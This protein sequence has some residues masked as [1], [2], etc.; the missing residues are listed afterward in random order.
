[1]RF[2]LW[3]LMI[4]LAVLIVS[5][6][7]SIPDPVQPPDLT[8]ETTSKNE[9]ENHANH[10]LLSLQKAVVSDDHQSV[11]IIP[12][13]GAEMH[14]NA[15]KMLEGGMCDDCLT[16][17]NVQIPAPGE[18]W[19]DLTIRHPIENNL[20]FTVFDP[21]A[22]FITGADFTFPESQRS[23]SLDSTYPRL[24]NPDGYT[25]LFNPTEFPE[26]SPV[27]PA[28]KYF[29]GKFSTGGDL[30]ASL[31]PFIA[32]ATEFPRRMFL[33]GTEETETV[34]L[35]VP[36]G[37][38]QFGYAID[39]CWSDPGIPVTDPETDFPPKANCT[40][41]YKITYEIIGTVKPEMGSS[42]LLYVE[43]SD[44]QGLDTIGDARLEVPDLFNGEFPLNFSHA[45]DE[46]TFLFKGTIA[47]L[48]GAEAGSYPFLITI[49]SIQPD[50]N[51]GLVSAYQV[52][53]IEIP[54]FY[55]P[56][57]LADFDPS[58][59]YVNQP[60]HFFDDGSH[61]PDGGNIVK[62]EWD[63]NLDGV[64]DE[65][66]ADVW[67][68]WDTA[69]IYS[70]QFRVTDDE[71]AIGELDEPL[72]VEII[73][74]TIPVVEVTPEWLNCEQWISHV[75][76]NCLV[77]TDSS[78][79]LHFYD[80]TDPE[81]P[82]W[83]CQIDAEYTFYPHHFASQ[84]GYLY[85]ALSNDEPAML[86]IDVDPPQETH[87]VKSVPLDIGSPMYVK[88]IA[89]HD[90]LAW[91]CPPSDVIIFVD[92]TIPEDATQIGWVEAP[93]SFSCNKTVFEGEYTYISADSGLPNITVFKVDPPDKIEY[94][95]TV[96]C[97]SYDIEVYNGYT[98][99]N[100]HVETRILDIDP[101]DSCEIINILP[102]IHGWD[103][104]VANGYLYGYSVGGWTIFDIDP[105]G[106]AYIVREIDSPFV[107]RNCALTDGYAY[108][109]NEYV[110]TSIIDIDPPEE[111][112]I[113]NMIQNVNNVQDI[114]KDGDILY[115]T[116]QNYSYDL[117]PGW[118]Q[119]LDVT[120]PAITNVLYSIHLPTYAEELDLKDGYAFGA[121]KDVL[122]VIDIDPPESAHLVTEFPMNGTPQ[123]M[124]IDGSH[125]YITNEFGLNIIDISVPESPGSV[126][127]IPVPGTPVMV[128]TAYGYAY[129]VFRQPD[130]SCKMAVVDIDPPEDAFI[131]CK[132][133]IKGDDDPW[134]S[135]G[136]IDIAGSF[137]YIGTEDFL[138]IVD[139]E[140][141][142][143]P[144]IICDIES[145]DE[146]CTSIQ[147]VGNL[148][149]VSW[150]GMLKIIDISTPEHAFIL[151]E[152][153]LIKGGN[154]L[155]D[156]NYIYTSYYGLRIFEFI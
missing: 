122:N 137:V 12:L 55:N 149:Y 111:A 144:E 76:G 57:A 60:V 69:G 112:H 90:N 82:V 3:I 52:C 153:E 43:I 126:K 73:K 47:N 86:V 67:H 95:Q 116:S 139:I 84:D 138:N 14:L 93:I 59:A 72:E 133:D 136:C 41:A 103:F 1:M 39:V 68:S 106:D 85:V 75:E 121:G 150:G 81:N 146:Y 119:L 115:I 92:I 151:D 11:E 79:R 53:N 152:I 29:P 77:L 7:N 64:Y 91:I 65:E 129:V 108:V 44:H 40:E 101:P 145:V 25:S 48:L 24:L 71:G 120:D 105:P 8:P 50:P 26:D 132:I 66:G 109:M 123:A 118:L 62:Y 16:I 63:W 58:P 143:S 83:I 4:I 130:Y 124:V 21:R 128:D 42:A 141:P 54:V 22:I 99:A 94:I 88:S 17:S 35:K 27:L 28:L 70:V 5:C 78:K 31:N 30:S 56:V 107:G 131:V 87:L 102:V 127:N 89:L 113:V 32:Y 46:D 98:F 104:E 148:A 147:I 154:L 135:Y 134:Y 45:I 6:S 19:L 80:I 20:N 37:G 38:F 125:A 61:D 100:S 117:S 36:T 142:E 140:Q 23:I 13:H 2:S 74:M 97:H 114:D 96:S 110:A 10:Y 34:K 18:L 155:I 15:V 33:P 9:P 51:L 156:G 49:D